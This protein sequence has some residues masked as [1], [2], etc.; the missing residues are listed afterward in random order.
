MKVLIINNNAMYDTGK[1]LYLYPNTGQ[2]I[3]GLKELGADVENFHFREEVSE[4]YYM[5]S[6]DILNSGIRITA[7]KKNRFK[8]LAYLKGYLVGTKRLMNNDFTY[9]FYPNSFSYLALLCILFKKPFG[10]YIRGEKGIHSRTSRYLFKHACLVLT[11]S[12][13]FT[14]QVK[15]LGGNGD[16][17]RPMIDFT[18]QDIVQDREYRQK[19]SYTILFLSR[20]EYAKG[21]KELID[22]LYILTNMGIRN[23]SLTIVGEGPDYHAIKDQIRT[24]KLDEYIYLAGLV[25]EAKHIR[26]YYLDSDVFICPSHHEGFPRV[27][28]EAM[29]FGIPIITTMVGSISYLMKDKHNCLSIEPGDATGIA[30]KIRY[31]IDDYPAIREIAQNATSTISTYMNQTKESHGEQLFRIIKEELKSE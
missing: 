11:V 17:I 8:A 9:I 31:I 3:V 16:T 26:Q 23:I 4:S 28:Y 13:A 18:C 5:A 27:L 22:A 2:F 24:L 10:L 15:A 19:A 7:L 20:I 21:I 29:I 14:N 12:P 1:G 6:F 25:T 30:E